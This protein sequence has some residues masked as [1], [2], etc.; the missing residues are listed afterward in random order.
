[1]KKCPVDDSYISFEAFDEFLAAFIKMAEQEGKNLT[2][3]YVVG[4]NNGLQFS[5]V[6]EWVNC[7]GPKNVYFKDTLGQDK[8]HR[9]LFDLKNAEYNDKAYLY[10]AHEVFV[11]DGF[12]NVWL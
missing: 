11:S 8:I 2:D 10:C 6:K 5:H 4:E 12:L 7:F 3:Q 1:M 9:V